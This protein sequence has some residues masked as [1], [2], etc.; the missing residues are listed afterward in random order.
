[1]SDQNKPL[2]KEGRRIPMGKY[3][4]EPTG[5]QKP[6]FNLYF[7]GERNS[8]NTLCQY[9]LGKHFPRLCW[10]LQGS[11]IHPNSPQVFKT[12]L[13][14]LNCIFMHT[15][16]IHC[17]GSTIIFM[18]RSTPLAS[19][20]GTDHKILV[21]FGPRVGFWTRVRAARHCVTCRGSSQWHREH[22]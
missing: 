19:T 3:P 10:T 17:H 1:M 18:P 16:Q 22:R 8:R 2:R 15:N 11:F 12:F 13:S 20:R 7:Q 6:L 9:T 5:Q 4:T 14:S 21:D